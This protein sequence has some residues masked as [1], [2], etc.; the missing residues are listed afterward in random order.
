M[1]PGCSRVPSSARRVPPGRAGAPVGSRDSPSR[2]SGGRTGPCSAC[3]SRGSCSRKAGQWSASGSGA[4]PGRR[5]SR[6]IS[7]IRGTHSGTAS[8]LVTETCVRNA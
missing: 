2:A 8:P 4:W 1:S 7:H 6:K 5:R 3:C